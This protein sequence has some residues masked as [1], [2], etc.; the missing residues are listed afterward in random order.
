MGALSLFK[1]FKKG[2]SGESCQYAHTDGFTYVMS[3]DMERKV[4]ISR[5]S[6]DWKNRVPGKK[7]V[8]Q[9]LCDGMKWADLWEGNS[10]KTT[11]QVESF[12]IGEKVVS[13]ILF[14]E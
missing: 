14:G 7:V 2:Y 8:T 6:S 4:V 3:E 12:A 1:D 9:V 11:L 5:I 10:P 13:T